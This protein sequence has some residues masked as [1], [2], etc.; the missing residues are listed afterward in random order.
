MEILVSRHLLVTCVLLKSVDVSFLNL[1][2]LKRLLNIQPLLLTWGSFPLS[3]PVNQR[4]GFFMIILYFLYVLFLVFGYYF[5]FKISCLL[6]PNA[7]LYIL[8][9]C[10]LLGPFYLCFLCRFIVSLLNFS[11]LSSFFNIFFNVSIYSLN[12]ILKNWLSLSFP[13]TLCLCFLGHILRH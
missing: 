4:F 1:G 12:L 6:R 9:F 10:L 7:L 5:T 2:N 3:M 13:S 11:I 8:I